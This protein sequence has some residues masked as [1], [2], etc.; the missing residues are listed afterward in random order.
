MGYLEAPLKSILYRVYLGQSAHQNQIRRE[1]GTTDY[2]PALRTLQ[3]QAIGLA[4]RAVGKVD[5]RASFYARLKAL[6][7]VLV[8]GKRLIDAGCTITSGLA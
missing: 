6:N 2:P 7:A 4:D 3:A 1:R 5:S 8:H